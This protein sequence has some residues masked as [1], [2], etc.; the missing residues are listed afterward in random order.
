M[1][2]TTTENNYWQANLRLIKQLD[3]AH[4]REAGLRDALEILVSHPA[5]DRA[6]ISKEL[7]S[8]LDAAITALMVKP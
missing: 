6:Y 1:T 7:A 3:A 5:F 2:E 8:K 4:V